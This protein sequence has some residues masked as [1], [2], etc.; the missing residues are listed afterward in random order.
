MA[1]KS[2]AG[3]VGAVAQ[4]V[5]CTPA[6]IEST[7]IF[8]FNINGKQISFTA[9]DTTVATTV[10]GLVAA[11]NASTEPEAMEV[12]ATDTTTEVT[13]T[14]DTAGKPFTVTLTETDGGGA[15]TQTFTLATTQANKSPND[16][17][18]G[19]NWSDGSVPG[20][21]DT[22][23]IQHSAVSLLWNLDA[24]SAVTVTN[25]TVHDTF[26]GQIGLPEK[27]T[28]GA[29]YNEYRETHLKL[30]ITN[31]EVRGTN[32]TRLNFNVG[33]V[34]TAVDVFGTGTSADS[35]VPT[36]L[37]LGTHVSNTASVQ[38]GN[39]GIAFHGGETSAVVTL[40]A[41]WE[42]SAANDVIMVC[43]AGTTLT[44][45]DQSNGTLT[46]NSAVTTMNKSG[47]TWTHYA[48][49]VGTI[50]NDA[51]AVYYRSDGTWTTL[52]NRGIFDLSRDNRARTGTNTS[53]YAG[54]SF[55]D[56]AKTVTHSNGIDLVHCGIGDLTRLDV[57]RHVTLTPSA[58]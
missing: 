27:N 43:G 8:T 4:V 42:S 21:S 12:T 34:Q 57:G 11:W 30:A 10:A 40:K 16:V 55:I 56:S 19:D 17:N 48:G 36:M 53:L 1:T 33:T 13:L 32:S 6:T 22:I 2:W 31:L 58:V 23:H 20:A 3:Q 24:L 15:D 25:L 39:V 26:T 14:A 35:N 54:C 46:T 47:G 51:G 44:T 41:G 50:N 7:D 38:K 18:D 52:H 9:T 49:A 45:I 5:T 28:D 37:F 29:E